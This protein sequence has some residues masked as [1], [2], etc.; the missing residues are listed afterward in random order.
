MTPQCPACGL[1]L[2]WGAAT[3]YRPGQGL[4][5]G[6][7]CELCRKYNREE[8]AVRLAQVE[9]CNECGGEIG[10]DSDPERY[11]RTCFEY[12]AEM[13]KQAVIFDGINARYALD[14]QQLLQRA[15]NSRPRKSRR[16]PQLAAYVKA[17]KKLPATEIQARLD[18]MTKKQLMKAIGQEK[19]PGL[20]AIKNAKKLAG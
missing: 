2:G 1:T 10:K 5:L 17:N 4:K 14:M 19:S 3:L 8:M 18:R 13:E 9:I 11:C 6:K 12:N 16:N 15:R 7:P 20:T